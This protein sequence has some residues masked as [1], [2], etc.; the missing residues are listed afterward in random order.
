[1]LGRGVASRKT[2]IHDYHVDF[3]SLGWD[4]QLP[5][6]SPKRNVEYRNRIFKSWYGT[7]P[8]NV[9]KLWNRLYDSG[10]IQNLPTSEPKHLL[11][12]LYLMRVYGPNEETLAAQM[13]CDAKTFRKY[14]WYYI[15]GISKEAP[16]LV[17]S[18]LLCT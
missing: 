2:Y 4:L 8:D 1:L 12:A 14:S 7:K 3:F 9:R 15:E 16:K 18:I 10:W 13:R 5:G 17:S 11:W 6:E